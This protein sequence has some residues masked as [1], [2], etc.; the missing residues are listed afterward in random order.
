MGSII[1]T[2]SHLKKVVITGLGA[3]TPIGNNLNE[4]WDSLM[5]GR[6]GITKISYFDAQYH[7]CRIAGEVKDFNPYDYLDRKDVKRMDRFCQFGVS[8][9]L[10]ALADSQLVI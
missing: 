2:N 8:A 1:M 6:S 4:Y 10:Q 5:A 3:I 7:V 9:S